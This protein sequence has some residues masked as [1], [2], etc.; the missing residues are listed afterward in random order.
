MENLGRVV[1]FIVCWTIQELRPPVLAQDLLEVGEGLV[2]L[3][4]DN[5]RTLAGEGT[6][7]STHTQHTQSIQ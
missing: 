6:R 1:C 7:I 4:N 3:Q 5:T 2:D